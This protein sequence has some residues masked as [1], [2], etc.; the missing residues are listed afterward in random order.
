MYHH[1]FFDVY[2]INLDMFHLLVIA[3]FHMYHNICPHELCALWTQ[4]GLDGG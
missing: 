3:T 1:S 2:C 4:Q